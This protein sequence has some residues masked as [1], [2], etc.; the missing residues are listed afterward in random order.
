MT[1]PQKPVTDG[2]IAEGVRR[3]LRRDV[4]L[5]EEDF[6][7]EVANGAV[8][9]RGEV[10]TPME[11]WAALDVAGL[12]YGVGNLVDRVT[13]L[14]G[15]PGGGHMLEELVGA[16]LAR[17]GHL[18]TRRIHAHVENDFVTLT[19]TVDF[20]YQRLAAEK[21]VSDVPGVSGVRNEIQVGR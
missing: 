14:P 8:T 12:T 4:R 7:V 6:E 10:V 16:A 9:L 11:K 5:N 21:A 18:D 19:G 13:V 1:Q 3:A 17:V 20:L 2:E 15:E